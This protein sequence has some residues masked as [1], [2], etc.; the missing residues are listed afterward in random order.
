MAAEKEKFLSRWSRLKS[1]SKDP[2][3]GEKTEGAPVKGEEAPMPVLPALD[4]LT[5][6]SDFTGF[7]HPKVDEALRRAALKKLFS[8]PHFNVPDPYEP[9]SGDWTGGEP[10]SEE[11]L[12]TLNQ[13]RTLLF[14][15]DEK[16]KEAPQLVETPAA[17]T[18]SEDQ[19]ESHDGG[20]KDA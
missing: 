4:E 10:I 5:S 3:P 12:A 15:Q 17:A 8:D 7:M 16:K 18:P 14:D 13:A 2:G 9:F 1:E 20:R 6:E 11:M 19:P